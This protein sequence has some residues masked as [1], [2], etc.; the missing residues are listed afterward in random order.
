MSAVSYDSSRN[1]PAERREE[2]VLGR[3]DAPTGREAM[4]DLAIARPRVLLRL[5]G[6]AVLALAIA[7]YRAGGGNWWLFALLLFAPDVAALGY[8]AGTG[9]GAA[10]YNIVH[11][12]ALPLAL[13]GYGLW[14]GSPLALSLAL[15]WLAHIGMDRTMGFG[16]KYATAFKDTHLGRV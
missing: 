16:L 13:L 9:V 3:S 12:Y 6:A 4:T 5:E 14:G 10:I 11:T 8:L 15:I 2:P 7:G 1:Q